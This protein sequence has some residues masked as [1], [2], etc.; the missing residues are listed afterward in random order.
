MRFQNLKSQTNL[1]SRIVAVLVAALA[2]GGD[3]ASAAR[4]VRIKDISELQGMRFNKLTGIGLVTGLA[5]TGS[6]SPIT[7]QFAQNFLARQGIR[8]DDQQRLN[9]RT[10]TRDKTDNLSVVTVTAEIP[11]FARRGS[12]VDVTVSAFDDARSLQ[13]G[14]LMLTPLFGVD[15]EVYALAD[16]GL[17]IGGFSFSGDAASVTK[18]HPTV[19]LIPNGA[20]IEEEIRTSIGAD[21]RVRLLLHHPDYETASRVATVIRE[22]SDATATVIDPGTIEIRLSMAQREDLA[23][24]IGAIQSLKVIPDVK[25]RVV[26]NERTGT[27]IIGENVK[28]STVGITHANLAVINTESPQVFQPAPFT[29]ADPVVTPNTE[30]DVLE[31]KKK[32]NVV[33]QPATVGDLAQAL[34]AL[35]VTP[36]DLSSIFQQLKAAGAL[37]AELVFR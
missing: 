34:N 25:A 1:K 4:E 13:G 9:V 14:V 37:H 17:S 21:G 8:P 36:R 26:I 31:E 22:K 12:R 10:D 35:G 15:G 20:V 2:L 28:I 30:I 3:S 11:P 6:K 7:R 29:N 5:G 24:S 27:I 18:N 16:G 32:I 33:D 19:G 23:A